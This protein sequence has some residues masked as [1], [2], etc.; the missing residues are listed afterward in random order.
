MFSGKTNK[1]C[2]LVQNLTMGETNFNQFMRLSNQLVIADQNI[3][4]GENFSLV[5]LPT[6]SK[7]MAEQ[8]KLAHMVV[9]LVD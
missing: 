7:H 3:A 1:K 5:L 4:R 6:M 8:I 2:R 9:D